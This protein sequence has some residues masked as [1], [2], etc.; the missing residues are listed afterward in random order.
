MQPSRLV[1]R[2][3]KCGSDQCL[4]LLLGFLDSCLPAVGPALHAGIYDFFVINSEQTGN[5][6]DILPD[7]S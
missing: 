2:F 7:F 3:D 5:I 1:Y 6:G 4:L